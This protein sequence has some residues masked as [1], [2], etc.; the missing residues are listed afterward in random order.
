MDFFGQ[1]LEGP[2]PLAVKMERLLQ[3]AQRQRQ[4][5]LDRI[6]FSTDRMRQ[7][8][9]HMRM[10]EDDMKEIFNAWRAHPEEWMRMSSL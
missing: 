9:T 1:T 3:A 8:D 4:L 6:S 5:H 10:G 2:M 7:F